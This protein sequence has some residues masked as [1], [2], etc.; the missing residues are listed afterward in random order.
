MTA[1]KRRSSRGSDS[2]PSSAASVSLL[3]CLPV[4]S[5]VC[6]FYTFNIKLKTEL[7]HYLRSMLR[8]V[9][10]QTLRDSA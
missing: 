5:P 4:W 6:E 7:V 3:W 2:A 8:R 1:N 9:W 10:A